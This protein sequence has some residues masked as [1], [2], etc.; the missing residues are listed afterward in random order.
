MIDADKQNIIMPTGEI[1][2]LLKS[3]IILLNADGISVKKAFLFGSY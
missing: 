3:Y 2:E 1:I